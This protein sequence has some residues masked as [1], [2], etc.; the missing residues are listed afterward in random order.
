MLRDDEMLNNHIKQ[1]CEEKRRFENAFQGILR[2]ILEKPIEKINDCGKTKLDYTFFRQGDKHII[3]LHDVLN[4]LVQH[5]KNALEGGTSKA[6]AFVLVSEPGT[7]K[8]FLVNYLGNWYKKFLQKAGNCK[9][10]FQ[11]IN[12]E[13]LGAYAKIPFLESQTYEDPM[14]LAMNLFENRDDNIKYLCDNFGFPDKKIE[15]IYKN[16]RPLGADSAYIW[17][18]IRNYTGGDLKKMLEFIKIVSVSTASNITT[19]CGRYQAKEKTTSSAIDLIGEEDTQRLFRITD[20]NNPARFNLRRGVL[21]RSANGG[22][23]FADELFKNKKD[24]IQEYLAVI[25]EHIIQNGGYM[26]PMDTFII[27]TTNNEEF[28]RFKNEE[29]EG[30]IVSRCETC[31]VPHIT[32]YKQQMQVTAYAIG[33]RERKTIA[34]NKLH[35]DPNLI[36]AIS[37]PFALSAL[38]HTEKLTII[39]T[40]KLA[41]NEVAGDKS[42]E[43]LAE[44][45]DKLSENVDVTK[46]FGQKGLGFRNLG[47]T[48]K[49]LM[50]SFETNEGECMFA[51]DVFKW[52]KRVILDYIDNGAYRDKYLKDI[53]EGEKLYRKYI[54]SEVYNAY[55]DDPE[56]IKKDV[57]NY[58]NM[59]I[60]INADLGPDKMWKYKDPQTH[61]WKALKI[62]ERYINNIEEM[63]G[64]KSAE[65]KES[66]RTTIRKIH[67]QRLY[68]DPDYDFMD[69]ANLVEAVTEV[70]I[71]SD[72]A[73]AASLVGA[74]ANR[75]SEEGNKLHLR[76]MDTLI[77]KMGHCKTCAPKTIEEF[78]NQKNQS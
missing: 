17:E 7:G 51:G 66:F 21:A 32:N 57:M 69:N 72:V 3:G 5:I 68:T 8:T 46:R 48:I 15:E 6:M 14:I 50:G 41:A 34:G 13:Q 65:Q 59:V 39:E 64:H 22:I 73:G 47:T 26:W 70:R 49:L 11:F 36:Y 25:E 16:Y 67:G 30:P 24:L 75:T 55:R 23:H 71:K 37:V 56:A 60:G 52:I 40:M 9:Y 1:V 33:D 45:I 63:L 31:Y 35:M 18:D 77:N 27:A 44:I 78:L 42:F 58:V 29:G 20:I 12:L 28:N 10:T 43:T 74:L 2:M 54:K 62:D 53:N 76:I 61:A 38:P 4:D 19:I